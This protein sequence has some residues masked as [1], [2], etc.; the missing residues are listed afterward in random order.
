MTEPAAIDALMRGIA[1]GG[2]AVMGGALT[3]TAPPTPAR[4]AGL[5]LCASAIGHVLDNW[6][7]L[8]PFAEHASLITWML[9]ATGPGL[10][11]AFTMTLF[12]DHFGWRLVAR[13]AW[14]ARVAAA[15]R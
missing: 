12:D 6:D 9:S 15:S 7:V 4:W 10:F 5:A 1:I 13:W 2:F 14:S 3:V 8:R 11:W